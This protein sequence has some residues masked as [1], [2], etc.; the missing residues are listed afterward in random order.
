LSTERAHPLEQFRREFDTLFDRFFGGFPAPFDP[1]F[2]QMRWWDFG[3]EDQGSEVVVRAELPDFEEKD[4]DVQLHDNLLTIRAEK[5][6]EDG[7][8]HRSRSFRCTV[9][10]PSGADP[11]K[12][13]ATYRNGVLELHVPKTE[14]A[15]G[16]RIPVQ[17]QQAVSGPAK[18]QSETAPAQ[19]GKKKAS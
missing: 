17:G 5:Q 8:E 9:T 19:G 4:L 15:Q 2:G 14:Q 13:T 10:L 3:V 12:V 6:Q 11:D 1:E 7:Q 18:G 16:R